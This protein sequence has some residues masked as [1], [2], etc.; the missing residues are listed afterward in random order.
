MVAK[1]NLNE[2]KIHLKPL[3]S[4]IFIKYPESKMTM[5]KCQLWKEIGKYNS[6]TNSWCKWQNWSFRSRYIAC[7]HTNETFSNSIFTLLVKIKPEDLFHINK[8]CVL[9]NI[10]NLLLAK[11]LQRRK[12]GSENFYRNWSDYEFGF[13]SPSSEVWLGKCTKLDRIQFRMF[14]I[15]SI[16]ISIFFSSLFSY[17]YLS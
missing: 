5:T 7:F 3:S 2:T 13:G 17:Q 16:S 12:D 11:V 15:A 6:I 8:H 4:N 14:K 1:W 10:K 9:A